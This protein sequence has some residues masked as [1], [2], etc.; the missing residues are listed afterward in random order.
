[1][2][3]YKL[4]Q[5]LTDHGDW[6]TVP[7]N[8]KDQV[9]MIGHQS[10]YGED[11]PIDDKEYLWIWQGQGNFDIRQIE[12]SETHSTTWGLS[13]NKFYRGRTEIPEGNNAT[14]LVMT[15]DKKRFREIPNS[16][17]RDIA[18]QWGDDAEVHIVRV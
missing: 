11:K 17:L 8:I 16:L 6:K 14:V 7:E 2:N 1:M 9:R 5:V 18:R 15:P 13:Y 12:M 3:W 10:Y 4:N